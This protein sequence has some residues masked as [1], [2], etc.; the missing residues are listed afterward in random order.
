MGHGFKGFRF[1][2]AG[3]RKILPVLNGAYPADASVTYNYGGSASAT[4]K[5]V[6][7]TEGK[8]AEYTYQWYV[9]GAAVSGAT[10]TSYTLSTS[11]EITKRVYCKV[12][13]AAGTVTSRTATLTAKCNNYTLLSNVN[14]RMGGTNNNFKQSATVDMSAFESVQVTVSANS[15]MD[16]WAYVYAADNTASFYAANHIGY[17]TGTYTLNISGLDKNGYVYLKGTGESSIDNATISSV[18]LIS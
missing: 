2:G 13:N 12:T 15:D 1:G 14:L 10:G 9:D 4:F 18:V 3:A 16:V 7:E 11:T 6:I 17:K 5:V 8:P